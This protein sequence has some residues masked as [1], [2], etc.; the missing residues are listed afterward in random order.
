MKIQERIL[1]LLVVGLSAF[2]ILNK[3]NQISNLEAII[4]TYNMESN[5]QEAQIND[6]SQQIDSAKMA[7]YQKGFEDGKTQAGVALAQGGS[8]YNYVDG[9]HAAMSQMGEE[10]ALD[11][12][13]GILTELNNLRK[14]VPRLLNQVNQITEENETLKSFSHD[15]YLLDVL[16]EMDENA[17]L[18]YVEIL[19]LLTRS[20]KEEV[21]EFKVD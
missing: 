9:Y 13:K 17:D 8:L 10:V 1:W 15:S 14:M 6:L 12:S 2:H 11:V 5:I 20:S 18:T 16:L 3:V 7:E 4:T 19:D 21:L